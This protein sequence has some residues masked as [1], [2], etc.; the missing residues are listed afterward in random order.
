MGL[1][2]LQSSRLIRQNLLLFAGGFSGGLGGFVYNAIA[3][4]ILGPQE[5]GEMASL[6]SLYTI[7]FAI[8]LV[9][10]VVLARYAA[11]LQARELPAGIGFMVRRTQLRLLI[12]TVAFFIL[13]AAASF[14]IAA[15]LHLRSPLPVVWLGVA[16]SLCWYMAIPRGSLQGTQHF[17]SLSINQVTELA[18][19]VLGLVVLL[20]LGL[21]VN[22]AMLALV[23][24]CGAGLLMGTFMLRLA[25]PRERRPVE[26]PAVT[27]F[28]FNACVGTFGITL[29]FNLDVVLAKHFLP[30]HAAGIYGGLNK[31]EVIIYY[32]TLSI[33]QVLFPRVVEAIAHRDHPGRLLF[34]SAGLTCTAGLIAISVFA[35]VPH[36]IVNILF[37]QAFHDADPFI[38]VVGVSGL[39]LALSNLLVQFF[40]AVHDRWYIPVLVSGC[41]AQGLLITAF[42]GSLKQV[43]FSVVGTFVVLVLALGAR[44]LLLLPHLRPEMVDEEDEPATATAG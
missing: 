28:V 36:L 4:R 40:M 38:V 13:F 19:R 25:I 44:L 9:M 12:P 1:R 3:G 10:M 14:P 24:G 18:V 17:G 6:F 8:N 37:G 11:S 34:L 41:V 33:S 35:L 32:G 43:V 23:G 15:F 21:G 5:Y 26:L 7:G 27:S 30:A 39:C 22:G 16:I 20:A 31:I 2:R 29:L 42:H